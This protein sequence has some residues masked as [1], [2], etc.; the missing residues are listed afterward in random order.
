MPLLTVAI[1]PSLDAAV[2]D[3][4]R[5]RGASPDSLTSAALGEYLNSHQHRMYQ[6]STSS[7]LVEGVDE[8][9]VS[10]RTLLEHGDFGLGTFE[11][12]DGE[13]VILDGIIYQVRG[14]GSVTR[15]DGRAV[16]RVPD[17]RAGV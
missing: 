2:R 17:L 12:R 14:D 13:M 9:A 10:S 8:G 5:Q 1:P 4:V 15:R 11:T 3:A 7:A 6:I 16:G